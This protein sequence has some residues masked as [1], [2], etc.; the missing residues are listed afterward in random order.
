MVAPLATLALLKIAFKTYPGRRIFAFLEKPYHF[1]YFLFN[2]V[3]F[4]QSEK[5]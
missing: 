1:S 2:V 4:L 5:C 3:C